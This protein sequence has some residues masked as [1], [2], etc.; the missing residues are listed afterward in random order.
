MEDGKSSMSAVSSFCHTCRFCLLPLQGGH[1]LNHDD[2]IGTRA[3]S[4]IIYLTD[5]DDP[6][7]AED[8][9]ALELYPLVE[10]EWTL[11]VVILCLYC[12]MTCCDGCVG[13]RALAIAL[14]CGVSPFQIA[15]RAPAIRAMFNHPT[16]ALLGGGALELYPLVEGEFT[17]YIDSGLLL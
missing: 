9:G 10:G 4:F 12:R 15:S 13:V 2:V 3:V 1:L 8:G 17:C 14:F 11:C 16:A 6:W 7:T 5:P